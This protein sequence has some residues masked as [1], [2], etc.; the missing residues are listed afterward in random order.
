MDREKS[1]AIIEFFYREKL[2]RRLVLALEDQIE[3]NREYAIE[4]ITK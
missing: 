1:D 4:I 3:K 2:V